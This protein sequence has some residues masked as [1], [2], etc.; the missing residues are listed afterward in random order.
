[1]VLFAFGY[2]F[3]SL[4]GASTT[5]SVENKTW[6]KKIGS[7]LTSATNIVSDKTKELNKKFPLPE[8]ESDRWDILILGIRGSDDPDGGLLTDSI[9]LLSLNKTGGRAGLV[10][11]PRDIFVEMPGLFEGKVN[12]IYE[13]RLAKRDAVEFTKETFSRLAGVR[14]DNMIVFDFRAFK[15][16]IDAIGGIDINLKKP[17]NEKTQWGYEFSLPAGSN[18]LDGQ[19]ALYYA[20]SRYSSSDFDRSLRQQEIMLAI[21]EKVLTLGILGNPLKV[22]SLLNSWRKNIDTDLDI[23][24]GSNIL[25]VVSSFD[26]PQNKITLR[27]LSTENWLEET[28]IN[29]VYVLL[30]KNDDW[31]ALRE[32]FQNL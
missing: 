13:R 23:W 25:K 11:I 16:I 12:E 5:V 32:F 4:G 31:P 7:L 17:F 3:F 30:P 9:M 21:K 15:E 28:K 24:D 29:N 2:T 26:A 18:H 27:G 8:K 6:W 1:M 22:V 14:I 20:R 19:S 10:S